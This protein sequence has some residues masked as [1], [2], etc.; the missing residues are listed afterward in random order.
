[1][2]KPTL[3]AHFRGRAPS[4]IRIAGI[5]FAERQDET[6]AVNVAIGNVSLPMHPAMID[7]LGR[8]RDDESP[9]RDGVVRYTGTVGLDETRRAFLHTLASCGYDVEG[10]HCL[11]T[12]GGSQAMELLIN[13]LKKAPTNAEFLMALQ[14]R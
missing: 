13:R 3:S 2:P 7:R 12:D 1:M 11:V 5:R 8:L 4:A 10:L 14:D 9:F 6:E